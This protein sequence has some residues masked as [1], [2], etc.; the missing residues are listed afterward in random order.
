MI[1]AFLVLTL[2]LFQTS[3]LS[4]TL[5][6]IKGTITV[7]SVRAEEEK[8]VSPGDIISA[9]GKKSS[10]QIF[11][12]DGSRS[13]LRNGQLILSEEKKQEKTVL[14]LVKGVLFTHKSKSPARLDIKTKYASMGVRGTKFYIDQ[15][16]KET[17]L[18]VCEGKV[19]ISNDKKKEEVD[20]NEDVHVSERSKIEATQANADMLSMAWDGFKEM[21][22]VE[23]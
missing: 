15:S 9:I 5:K 13:L 8:K 17:Y 12:E 11:F 19:E 4:A 2:I 1:K 3:V 18:C 21:G 20:K 7:N 14:S 22:L 23:K 6:N 16:D 10:V